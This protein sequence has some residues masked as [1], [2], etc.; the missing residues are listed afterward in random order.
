MKIIDK[1]N[2]LVKRKIISL[3]RTGRQQIIHAIE[4]KR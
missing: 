3:S 1:N 2:I 4:Y